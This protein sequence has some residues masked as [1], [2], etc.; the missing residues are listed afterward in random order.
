MSNNEQ[1][2]SLRVNAHKHNDHVALIT[3]SARRVGSEIARFLHANGFRVV[4]HYRDSEAE[5]KALSD[6]LNTLRPDSAIYLQANLDSVDEINALIKKIIAHW[7]RLD[8]VVNNASRF[9]PTKVGQTSEQQ[10]DDLINS[11]FKAP[12]FIAQTALPFLLASTGC[13]INITDIHGQSA[14]R[15]Y[16]VYAAAKAGLTMLTKSLARE[17]GPQIRVN[18]VAPGSVMWPE[19]DNE[20]DAQMQSRLIQM[21]ALKRK[22]NPADIAKAV[23]FLIENQSMS[24]Q[25]I[26]VDCGRRI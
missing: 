3:G 6:Q 2:F 26:N 17:L 22:V 7:N 9:F 8:V 16:P 15:D 10:W 20:L 23:L 12:Y 13:I 1:E 21:T 25:I 19:G 5:A 18:A 11:N 4:I 24:G 14:L